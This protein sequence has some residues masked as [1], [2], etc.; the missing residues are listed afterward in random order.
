MVRT[1]RE[2]TAAAKKQAEAAGV[3]TETYVGEAE[4]FEAIVKLANDQAVNMI[5]VGSHGRPGSG[6]CSWQRYRE[7]HRPRALPGAGGR[8]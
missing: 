7:G 1:A 2:Y 4:A 8:S 5:V 3:K 6:D